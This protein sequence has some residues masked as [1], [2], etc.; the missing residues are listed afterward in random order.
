MLS[1]LIRLPERL[2]DGVVTLDQHRLGDAPM[3]AAGEDAEIG[4]RFDGGRPA[5]AALAEAFIRQYIERR[6]AGGPEVTYALRLP[7]ESLIGGVEVRRPRVECADFG[8]WVYPQFR[9]HGYARRGLLL[10]CEAVASALAGLA[11]L[12]VHIET[13]NLAS[14]R[15]A[16]AAGFHSVG[17]V[18]ENGITRLRLVRRLEPNLG[19]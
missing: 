11:E 12:S 9:G 6:A 18:I 16:E 5:T 8:Y 19:K 2:T 7:D 17:S 14:L 1:R 15:T 4:R 3:V 13:D 10:L